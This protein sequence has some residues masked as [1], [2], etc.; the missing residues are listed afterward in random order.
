MCSAKYQIAMRQR[1]A[2][3]DLSVFQSAPAT[4]QPVK[5]ILLSCLCLQRLD[6]PATGGI[7]ILFGRRLF[8]RVNI[9]V[10]RSCR[11]AAL[12]KELDD[13]IDIARL[14]REVCHH[15]G[16]IGVVFKTIAICSLFTAAR[17]HKKD[18]VLKLGVADC[19]G[20]P[21][22]V[23]VPEIDNAA[24]VWMLLQDCGRC[25]AC[26]RGVPIGVWFSNDLEIR[27]L[28]KNLGDAGILIE[29]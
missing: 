4:L 12:Q 14:A 1:K 5:P 27:V 6:I 9:G 3:G 7:E 11:L 17:R 25:I 23:T 13:R 22:R 21:G 28:F 26:C 10:R 19:S 18:L 29:T 20:S 16:A 2:C 24:N 15:D 8:E